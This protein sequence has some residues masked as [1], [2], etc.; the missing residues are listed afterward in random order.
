M[1]GISRIHYQW[2]GRYVCHKEAGE[3]GRAG[4]SSKPAS[5]EVAETAGFVESSRSISISYGW[6]DASRRA[7]ALPALV[8]VLPLSAK[9][10]LHCLCILNGQLSTSCKIRLAS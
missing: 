7:S 1:P 9:L 4:C 2:V 5:G 6:S 10:F 8:C 3:G